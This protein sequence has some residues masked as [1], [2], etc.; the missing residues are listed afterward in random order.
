VYLTEGRAFI[1]SRYLVVYVFPLF[2]LP[3]MAVGAVFAFKR[4][5]PGAHE[6]LNAQLDTH[7][8]TH[9]DFR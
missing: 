9:G 5:K 1:L 8:E 3:A 6:A 7:R 2:A 4:N